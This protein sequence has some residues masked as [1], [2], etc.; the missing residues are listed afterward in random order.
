MDKEGFDEFIAAV[1]VVCAACI[2]C[3]EE[4]CGKCPVRESVTHYNK[5]IKK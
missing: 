3:N 5:T 1:D 4:T 2:K